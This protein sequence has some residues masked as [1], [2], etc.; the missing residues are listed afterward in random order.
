MLE[1][2]A[3]PS[4]PPCRADSTRSGW[5][6]EAEGTNTKNDSIYEKESN[7]TNRY[8]CPVQHFTCF[9]ES[10]EMFELPCF[11]PFCLLCSQMDCGYVWL[12]SPPYGGKVMGMNSLLGR[13]VSVCCFLCCLHVRSFFRMQSF[14]PIVQNPVHAICSEKFAYESTEIDYG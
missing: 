5:A 9:S 1:T 11:Y 6:R 13:G 2:C 7:V 14:P 10:K 3:V 4:A 8:E 12:A